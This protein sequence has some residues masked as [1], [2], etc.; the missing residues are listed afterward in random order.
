M[1][2]LFIVCMNYMYNLHMYMNCR[3]T[4][5]SLVTRLKEKRRKKCASFISKML[6]I[7][8]KTVSFIMVSGHVAMV[9]LI[10]CH[11][12]DFPCKYFHT[13]HMCYHGDSCKFSHAP[14]NDESYDIL[15]HVS[16]YSMY[17]C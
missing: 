5:V 8:V 6:A 1:Y 2:L 11:V 13:R 16:V 14:L 10:P 4:T 17:M 7:K 12:G 9:T 3:V 15:M